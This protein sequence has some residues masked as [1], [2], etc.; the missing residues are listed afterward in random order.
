M[1]MEDMCIWTERWRMRESHST[2][3]HCEA[4]FSAFS[5]GVACGNLPNPIMMEMVTSQQTHISQSLAPRHDALI[6][7]DL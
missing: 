7:L 4:H 2:I 6:R 1:W 5:N 3:I